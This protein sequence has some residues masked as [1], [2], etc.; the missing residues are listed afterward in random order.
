MPGTT[1]CPRIDLEFPVF[2]ACER[3]WACLYWIPDFQHATMPQLFLQEELRWRD[4]TYGGIAQQRGVLVLSS[5]AA[6]ADFR[7]IF[8]DA[9]VRPRVWSFCSNLGASGSAGA[10]PHQKYGLAEKFLYVPNQFWVHKDHATVFKALGLL[11]A[12]GICP[13][14]VCTGLQEDYRNPGHFRMLMEDVSRLGLDGQVKCLGLVPREDQV[15][16]FRYA[17]GIVQPSLFEGWSTVVEDAKSLG[18]PLILSDIA[19]HKEQMP[20]RGYFFKAGSSE[21]LARVLEKVWPTLA[22][23]PDPQ[24]E[25]AALDETSRSR[26]ELARRFMAIVEEAIALAKD[27][28]DPTV[29][30]QRDTS[31]IDRLDKVGASVRHIDK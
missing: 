25:Q 3:P 1:Q 5:R 28:P 30:R 13:S 16:I 14:V 6:L 17:A 9:V 27:N 2:E 22:P 18:R 24:A 10:N 15:K 11:K 26:L 4:D 19:P 29:A 12:K 20:N 21:D 23:G 31:A 8:P 7:R